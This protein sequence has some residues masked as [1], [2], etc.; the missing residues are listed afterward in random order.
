MDLLLTELSAKLIGLLI[1]LALAAV[2]FIIIN[3]FTRFA[4][5]AVERLVRRAR[6]DVAGPLSLALS[7]II[8]VGG[9]VLAGSTALAIM[10]V[11]LTALMAGL[12]LTSVALGFALKDTV[13]QAITGTLL[14]IQRPF[15]IGDL[16]EVENVEGV[17]VDIAIR[18]TNLRTADGIHVLVPNN[19]VWQG[20]VRNK[21]Y[22]PGRRFS[23][24]L[25]INYEND[26]PTTHRVLL[27]AVRGTP[28]VL[29]NPEPTVSFEAFD[30]TT[31]RVVIRYWAS[32]AN[33]DLDTI[34]S[35]QTAVTRNVIDLARAENIRMP[36][37]IQLPPAAD[38]A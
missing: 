11:N 36:I 16:I 23:F 19:K 37:S 30:P 35:L 26:L 8:S 10:G 2:L 32:S 5:R 21:S 1:Q 34:A 7:R 20:V 18:T 38:A 31:I 4:Q 6:S 33:T 12:G 25:G 27:N 3:A 15:K 22:F 14:L 24:T 17:V 13:E 28:G 9:F 29:A